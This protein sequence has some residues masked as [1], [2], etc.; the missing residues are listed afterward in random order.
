VLFY[1]TDNKWQPGLAFLTIFLTRAESLKQNTEATA[2]SPISDKQEQ[3]Q[4]IGAFNHL[5]SRLS[6]QLPSLFPSTRSMPFGPGMYTNVASAA[7]EAILDAED[8][9]VWHFL[10]SLAVGSDMNQQQILVTE[11]RDKVLENCLKA[12]NAERAAQAQGQNK[13]AAE[14]IA[15]NKIRNVNTFLHA[16]GLDASQISVE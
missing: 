14:L 10:A 2:D 16:L 11:V 15:S 6:G 5:F 8:E 7:S 13:E 4:W 3:D 12:K 9:P 1:S